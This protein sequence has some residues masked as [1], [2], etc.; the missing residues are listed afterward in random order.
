MNELNDASKMIEVFFVTVRSVLHE[1]AI[2]H[3]QL[4]LS[5]LLCLMTA[6]GHAVMSCS[7][8][9]LLDLSMGDNALK[10]LMRTPPL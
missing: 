4:R 3:I 8:I 6:H 10:H 2:R 9:S 1:I 5:Y 7:S